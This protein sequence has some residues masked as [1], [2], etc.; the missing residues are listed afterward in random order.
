MSEPEI[1]INKE[2]SQ[3][4]GGTTQTSQGLQSQTQMLAV[5]SMSLGIL[6]LCMA[7]L[8]FVFYCSIPFDLIGLGFG[9]VAYATR[10]NDAHKSLAWSAIIIN[11]VSLMLTAICYIMT[12]VF[13]L[14]LIRFVTG[15]FK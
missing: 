14:S 6:G 13:S 9:I 12:F 3:S 10:K 8:P 4:T 7:P 1:I 2:S 11:G 5:I 15:L